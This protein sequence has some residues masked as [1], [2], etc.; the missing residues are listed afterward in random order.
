MRINRQRERERGVGVAE[1]E[2]KEERGWGKWEGEGGAGLVPGA[3]V[4]SV[5]RWRPRTGGV[6]HDSWTPPT[7][8][9][10]HSLTLTPSHLPAPTHLKPSRP[11]CLVFRCQTSA[12]AGGVRQREQVGRRLKVN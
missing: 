3:I 12:A 1:E 7:F 10:T 2:E 5:S 8:L 4:P 9:F 11:V 6:S